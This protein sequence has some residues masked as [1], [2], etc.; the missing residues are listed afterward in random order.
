MNITTDLL[1]IN[2]FSRPGKKLKSKK[3]IV[4]H[5]VANP[6][7]TAKQNRNFFEM[8]KTGQHGYGSA[9]YIVDDTQILKCIPDDEMAYHVGSKEYTEYGLSISSY[10]NARTI[11]IEFCHPDETGKPTYQTYKH[12]IELCKFLCVKYKLDPMEDITTHNAITGKD[13][14]KYYIAVDSEFFRLKADVKNRMV[15]S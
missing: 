6:G 8:R 2:E 1:S 10:P 14:P 11:G 9:Q 3:K 5:W 13:C 15:N 7:T 12:I 4:L